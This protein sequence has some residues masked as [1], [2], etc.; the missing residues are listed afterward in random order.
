MTG[1]VSPAFSD[2]DVS[3]VIETVDPR[4]RARRASIRENPDVMERVV[5]ENTDRLLERVFSVEEDGVLL[6]I[7]PRLLFDILLRKTARVLNKESYI[8]ERVGRQ[9]VPVFDAKEAGDF[10]ARKSVIPY[11]SDMLS[12]FTKI[13]SFTL[14]LGV[15]EG[16]WQKLRLNTMDIESL[17]H[18]CS[19]ID[20]DDRFPFYKRI[21]DVCLFISG[22]FPEFAFSLD[23]YKP[24][25]PLRGKGKTLE[26]YE[27][28]GKEYYRLAAEHQAARIAELAEIMKELSRH[29]L[30]AKKSLNFIADFY[31]R[32]RKQRLFDFDA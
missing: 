11:L 18:F 12:S 16:V 19:M 5:E 28:E 14:L 32:F 26:E 22:V 13:E 23:P 31:L 4:P 10:L 21:A 6:T 1:R 25:G 27:R 20:E 9:V 30:L 15:K 3:F 29:F 8:L 7:S 17:V 24:G 2:S